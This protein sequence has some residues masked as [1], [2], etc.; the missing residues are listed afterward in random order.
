M[1]NYKKFYK[2]IDTQDYY[3]IALILNPR[4]KPLLLDKE[5]GPVTAPK[6]IR[7]IKD[8]LHEQYPSKL[9]QEQSMSKLN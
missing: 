6:V 2:L 3:Y 9:S 4:F 8:T 7:S 5:L 1:K